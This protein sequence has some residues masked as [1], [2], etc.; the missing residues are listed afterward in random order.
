M[1]Y[2]TEV[3]EPCGRSSDKGKNGFLKSF[4][5]I[6]QIIMYVYLFVRSLSMV[7]HLSVYLFMIMEIEPEPPPLS[8][9][10]SLFLHCI[11]EARSH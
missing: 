4:E 8:Y 3:N 5:I 1:Y 6:L 7:Y 9:K 11:F 2:C 10:H